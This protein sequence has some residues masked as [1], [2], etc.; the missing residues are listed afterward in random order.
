MEFHPREYVCKWFT[1][2][3][4]GNSLIYVDCPDFPIQA[5][6][7]DQ[8]EVVHKLNLDYSPW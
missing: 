6:C 2:M 1:I 3:N 7:V 8:L 4:K 5:Y